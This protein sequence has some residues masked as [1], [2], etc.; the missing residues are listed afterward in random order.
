MRAPRAGRVVRLRVAP[1]QRWCAGAYRAT[2]SFKQTV[3]CPPTVNCGDSV[4]VAIGSTTF[5]PEADP[6]GESPG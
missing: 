6:H 4:E 3:R 2:V 1:P 5:T